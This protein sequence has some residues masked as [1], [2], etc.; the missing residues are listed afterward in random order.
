MHYRELSTPA[1][2]LNLD[3]LGYNLDTMARYCREQK[4]GLRPHTKT[5]KI[6]EV[7]R[8]QLDRGAV[9][10]TVAKV[11]EA[12]VMAE[13]GLDDIL[14]AFPIYGRQNLDRLAKLA[15]DRRILMSLDSEE[16]ACA[17]SAATKRQGAFV[18]VLVELDVGYH[19]CGLEPGDA[20]AKLAGKIEKLP[21]LKFRGLMTYFGN[22]WGVEGERRKQTKKVAESLERTMAAFAREHMPLEIVSG[23][24]T[25]SAPLASEIPGLTEIRPGTYAYNDLN[26]FYQGL[27]RLEDCAVRV[28]TTI[29]STAVAGRAIIDAGSKTLSSDRLASGPEK[30]NGCVTEVLDAP[31]FAL[32]EEH[33]YID[34]TRSAHQFHIGEVL[35]VIPNHVCPCVNLHDEVFLLRGEHVVGQWNVSGRGKIR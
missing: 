12:E 8:M 32:D 26:T 14:T 7:A 6:P 20:C 17:L 13:A 27:C 23:G 35:T 11:G 19:R 31:L 34:T 25:P 18:G 9:G 24:S 21:G 10:I 16:T 4:L 2:T 29:V 22:I 30:G 33:G 3:V 28:V 1:L 5:H 15:R